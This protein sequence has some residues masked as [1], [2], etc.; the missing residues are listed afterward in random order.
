MISKYCLLYFRNLL[1]KSDAFVK[2]LSE[3]CVVNHYG[4]RPDS[5]NLQVFVF[6]NKTKSY[7]KK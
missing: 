3:S 7:F 5:T 4:I 6:A 2:I 1:T